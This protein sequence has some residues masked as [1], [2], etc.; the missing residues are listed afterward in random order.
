MSTLRFQLTILLKI[1]LVS[2]S[3]IISGS[4][5]VFH[6]TFLVRK[7]HDSLVLPSTNHYN[8]WN[9]SAQQVGVLYWLYSRTALD[10]NKWPGPDK[11]FQ[12]SGLVKLFQS[13]LRCLFLGRR[14]FLFKKTSKGRW[15]YVSSLWNS[16]FIEDDSLL[17]KF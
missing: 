12:N 15:V 5:R 11:Q 6:T 8:K 1:T 4:S 7:S 10:V 9:Y 13:I 14:D 16:I 2:K 3:N 17:V